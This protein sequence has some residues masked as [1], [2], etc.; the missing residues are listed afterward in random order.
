MVENVPHL[1]YRNVSEHQ[2]RLLLP[3]QRHGD[4][5]RSRTRGNTPPVTV[6]T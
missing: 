1:C 5:R 4:G 2:G 6:E 3:G